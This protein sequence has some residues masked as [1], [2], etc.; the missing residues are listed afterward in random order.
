MKIDKKIKEGHESVS[1]SVSKSSGK[2]D[3]YLILSLLFIIS[4]LY[5]LIFGKHV[6]FYQ[7]NQALFI[8]SGD[9]FRQFASKPGGLLE[10]A[11]NFLTQCY[12]SNISGCFIL[13]SINNPDCIYLF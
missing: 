6:F 11:G 3:H 4:A 9:Y 12:H 8:Y 7:E 13:S 1:E 2:Y 5:F 10:Y